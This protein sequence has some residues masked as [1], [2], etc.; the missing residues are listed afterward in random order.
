MAGVSA[1]SAAVAVR[2]AVTGGGQRA[3]FKGV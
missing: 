2:A 3:N 1:K